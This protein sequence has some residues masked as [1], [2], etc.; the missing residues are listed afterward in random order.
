MRV[1]RR[2]GG[3][4][5][6]SDV[7]RKISRALDALNEAT[8]PRDRAIRLMDAA[9]L[10][11]ESASQGGEFAAADTDTATLLDTLADVEFIAAGQLTRRHA[12]GSRFEGVAGHV[13]E[14]MAAE[15]DI[16]DRAALLEAVADALDGV[17]SDETLE[18]LACLPY[19][20]GRRGWST[21]LYLPASFPKMVRT[22]FLAW[23]ERGA[24]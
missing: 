22:V 5:P 15:P 14:Q 13:F 12:T 10:L 2:P 17:V 6:M 4:R 9:A 20:P 18:S 7:D 8:N 16:A 21:D 19:H 3:G 11:R 1:V 24:A 23:R